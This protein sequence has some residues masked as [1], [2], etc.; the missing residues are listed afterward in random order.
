MLTL[1]IIIPITIIIFIIGRLSGK[2]A[3]NKLGAEMSKRIYKGLTWQTVFQFEFSKYKV[4]L[5]VV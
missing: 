4:V 3:A 1:I 5:R 2:K